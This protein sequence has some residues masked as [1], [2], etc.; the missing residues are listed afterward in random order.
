VGQRLSRFLG[1]AGSLD[2]GQWSDFTASGGP[3]VCCPGCGAIV[4]LQADK[5]VVSREG[6]VTPA[7][8]CAEETCGVVE[9]IELEA[10]GETVLR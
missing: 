4:E 5:H 2:P 10:Y 6:K 8:R 3:A 9:W 1:P 7:W